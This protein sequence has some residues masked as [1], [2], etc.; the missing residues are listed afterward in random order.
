MILNEGLAEYMKEKT[1]LDYRLQLLC[2][3][4]KEVDE[5]YD[6]LATER[7]NIFVEQQS[8]DKLLADLRNQQDA[9]VEAKSILEAE[10]EAL[11]I[12]RSVNPDYHFP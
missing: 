7:A 4:R 8:L 10:K 6:R 5:M 9:V 12:L 3:L 1:A 11:R 2:S